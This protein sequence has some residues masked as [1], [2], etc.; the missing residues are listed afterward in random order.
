MAYFSNGTEG[1]MYQEKYCERCKY[2]V[3]D[4]DKIGSDLGCPVWQLHELYNGETEWQPTLNRLIPMEPRVINGIR[5]IF[6]G[7]C[8]TFWPRKGA[9]E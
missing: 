5:H 6:A 7:E 2:W 3:R 9:T 1:L 4:I 8:T